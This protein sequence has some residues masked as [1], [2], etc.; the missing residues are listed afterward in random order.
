MP[1]QRQD[2]F[3]PPHSEGVSFLRWPVCAGLESKS[4]ADLSKECVLDHANSRVPRLLESAGLAPVITFFAAHILP[5]FAE[6]KHGNDQRGK[7]I[8]LP[9]A[10][11]RMRCESK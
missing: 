5:T 9:E 10:E 2:T 6:E 4:E 1:I 3:K 7:R 11:E 8:G